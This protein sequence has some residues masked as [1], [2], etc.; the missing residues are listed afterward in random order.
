MKDCSVQRP[1]PHR[2]VVE[3][4]YP[5]VLRPRLRQETTQIVVLFLAVDGG[6]VD[7][8]LP[9]ELPSIE[10][11]FLSPYELVVSGVVSVC[12][13]Q[14]WRVKDTLVAGSQTAHFYLIN[15]LINPFLFNT[16]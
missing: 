6:E 15:Q 1:L 11:R 4:T 2:R 14:P 10:P 16:N 9:A 13:V 3:E 5:R 12:N 7:V 8:I